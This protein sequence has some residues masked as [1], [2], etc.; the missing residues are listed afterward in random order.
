M[1]SKRA[2]ILIV[3]IFLLFLV[4][5]FVDVSVYGAPSFTFVNSYWGSVDNP[6]KVYPGSKNVVLV[7]ELVNNNPF[8]LESVYGNLSLPPGFTD[9]NGYNYSVASGYVVNGSYIR[10]YVNSGEIF[11]LR[12]TVNV[13]SGVGP[14]VYITS[15]NLTYSYYNASVPGLVVASYVVPDVRLVVSEF[16]AFSF[17]VIDA[18]WTAD[19][20]VVNPTSPSRDIT[21]H[22][23]IK[24]LGSEAISSLEA[25]LIF[26]PPFYPGEVRSS[27][28]GVD[29]GEVFELVFS[30]IDIDASY[31]SMVYYELLKL[32]YTFVGYG[33]ARKD[34]VTDLSFPIQIFDA[35]YPSLQFVSSEW[36][37]VDR[38]YPG[39]RG[40]DLRISIVNLGRFQVSNLMVKAY[41]P[42]CIRS[43]LGKGVVNLSVSGVYGFGDF[44]QINIGSLYISDTTVPGVYY[45]ELE[46]YG[47]G[48]VGSSRIMVGQNLTAP[49]IVNGFSS[50]FNVVSIRW[51]IGTS[52]AFAL[53]GSK[54]ISLA[55]DML[56]LGDEQISGVSPNIQ[57]PSGF[58]I[59]GVSVDQEVM[60]PGTRFTVMFTMD[61]DH[62]VSPGLYNFSIAL[63]YVLNPSAPYVLEEHVS[64][65]SVVIYDPRLFSS[66]VMLVE[67]FWG[68][69]QPITVYPMSQ[70][71]PLSVT[72][73]NNGPYPVEGVYVSIGLPPGFSSKLYNVSVAANIPVGSFSSAVYY[74]DIGGVEP[75]DYLFNVTVFYSVSIYG[76]VVK[77]N[78]TFSFY[79]EVSEVP[80]T[81]GYLEV[82]EYGWL[83]DYNVYPGTE[84]A[85]LEVSFVNYAPFPIDAVTIYVE[86]GLV[87]FRDD[88]K[89][90][91]VQGPIDTYNLFTVGLPLNISSNVVS[92]Y[93]N[94]SLIVQ[95]LLLSGGDGLGVTERFNLSVYVSELS[96][97]VFVSYVW[98]GESPGPGSSTILNLIFVNNYYESMDGLYVNVHLPQGFY[99]LSNNASIVGVTPYVL[100]SVTDLSR[101]LA[102]PSLL[103]SL[104]PT[105]SATVSKG[106]YIILS[107]PL[108]IGPDTA[109][110]S[111]TFSVEFNFIDVWGEARSVYSEVSVSIFGKTGYV[112][113]DE[114]RS[115]IVLG[116]RISNVSLV[117]RNSGSGA[118][119]DV[120]VSISS[121]NQ[122][123]AFSSAV[124]H[125]DVLNPGE[126]VTL[127]WRASVNPSSSIYGGV[128][129]LVSIFYVDPIGNRKSINQTIILYIEGI[130]KLKLIDI[131]IS[132]SPAYVNNTISVSATLVNIGDSTARNV[133]VELYG[134]GLLTRR[135]SYSFLGDIEE[136][137][138]IPFTVYIDT[139]NV[140]G[141]YTLYVK[142]TYYNVFNEEISFEYPLKL[143]VLEAP[144]S[145]ESG[146]GIIDF[147][148]EDIWRLYSIIITTI[149]I[150]I[151]V[152]LMYRTY[153]VS[154]RRLG[155]I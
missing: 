110:G 155:E 125:I 55:V 86:S 83:N 51:V 139:G 43:S 69:T 31:P 46:L 42:S 30:G 94:I 45:I 14:G 49:V 144:V 128:P 113:V 112:E 82:I 95:Y 11:R 48:V 151:A 3:S 60:S 120:Y 78:K 114:S 138:Q 105:D 56:Y 102:N 88:V 97:P 121:I 32:N 108:R 92:G 12:Y 81:G 106:D 34:Y 132:P 61:I 127:S 50:R 72:F 118:L 98:Q 71:N 101:L 146:G 134:E 10:G 25:S 28:Q 115:R 62:S 53:P 100:S 17:D 24:N 116:E 5:G 79:V 137:S 9:V 67:S 84:T 104:P 153:R 73:T 44:I 13:D 29:P 6:S 16:P 80:L 20:E 66:D 96:P 122:L 4:V 47:E 70:N 145:K 75:G 37:G 89:A 23:Y 111:Y 130:P 150:V 129:A 93:Y 41:L 154:K 40:V 59:K 131:S 135:D 142:V 149:F 152:F 136:G 109:I 65:I 124:K 19:G 35:Y 123:V 107:L 8:R 76:S 38:V 87:S 63:E 36:V 54:S 91:F 126:E 52:P 64:N 141:E 33:G 1:D 58:V 90:V 147:L 103:L 22:V 140:V 26:N 117:I 27:V 68:V 85:Q 39:S 133:E 77:V 2:S 21:L 119:Y 15:I 99:S 18:F 74:V 148:L 57:V 143:K 7:I